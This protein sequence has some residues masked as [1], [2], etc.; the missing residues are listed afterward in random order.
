M[1]HWFSPKKQGRSERDE[2]GRGDRQLV[3]AFFLV[4]VT[5]YR[6]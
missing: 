6:S 2:D 4:L 3:L 5:R 1:L